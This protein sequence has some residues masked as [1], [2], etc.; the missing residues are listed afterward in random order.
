MIL[1]VK[2]SKQAH[3]KKKFLN[4]NVRSEFKSFREK[5]KTAE[6]IKTIVLFTYQSQ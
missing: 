1:T 3:R 6:E 4:S 5:I 2:V